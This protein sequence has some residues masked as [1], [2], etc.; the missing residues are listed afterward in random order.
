MYQS[1]D[2]RRADD[3]HVEC[4]RPVTQ[5]IQV[6]FDAPLHLLDAVGLATKA[7]DLR[8]TRNTRLDPVA[9][10]IARDHFLIEVVVLECMGTRSYDRH[11][12]TQHVVELRQFVEAR[13]AQESA[14]FGDARIVARGLPDGAFWLDM[15]THRAKLVNREYVTVCT[16]AFLLE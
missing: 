8:P 11:V 14:H 9:I 12:A 7:V 1:G 4:E 15:Q 10:D 5:V 13:A 3:P 2:N 16:F 6:M